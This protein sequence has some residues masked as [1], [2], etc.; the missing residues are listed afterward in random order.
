MS[1]CS[2]QIGTA[3]TSGLDVATTSRHP[4][5]RRSASSPG[6]PSKTVASCIPVAP[7]SSRYARTT[8]SMR[9]AGTPCARMLSSIGGPTNDAE[10]GGRRDGQ[11]APAERDGQGRR[12]AGDGVDERAV[13]VEE[14]EG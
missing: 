9:S 10:L 3:N 7:K 11:A 6:T 2:A 1:P 5:A 4:A 14:D 8:S 13:E 12:D